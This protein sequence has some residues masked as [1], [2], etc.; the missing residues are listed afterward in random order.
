MFSVK[1][2]PSRHRLLVQKWTRTPTGP[3]YRVAQFL[4]EKMQGSETSSRVDSADPLTG[5]M[6]YVVE[7][8][9]DFVLG[10]HRAVVPIWPVPGHGHTR[11]FCLSVFRTG[12]VAGHLRRNPLN[13]PG[14]K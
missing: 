5:L 1:V 4:Q 8:T 14:R 12:S 7:G 13:G 9:Q 6:V 11:R 3:I 10:D 2:N